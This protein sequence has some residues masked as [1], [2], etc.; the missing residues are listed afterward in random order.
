MSISKNKLEE[1]VANFDSQSRIKSKPDL[2]LLAR[3]STF[4]IHRWFGKHST[5]SSFECARRGWTNK[6][7][8][9]IECKDCNKTIVIKSRDPLVNPMIDLVQSHSTGCYW[10]R[11]FVDSRSIPA[12]VKRINTEKIPIEVN[13]DGKTVPET[14]QKYKVFKIN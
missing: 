8:D 7:V 12:T 9:T 6:D 4:K 13:T 2:S 5:V 14:L 11:I 1:V 10:T 3:L